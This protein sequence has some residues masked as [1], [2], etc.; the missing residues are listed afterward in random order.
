MEK[1]IY[2]GG[3]GNQYLPGIPAR[4]ITVAVESDSESERKEADLVVPTQLQIDNLV[5]RY[6]GENPVLDAEGKPV[7]TGLYERVLTRRSRGG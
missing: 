1:L 6:K 5:T 4:D 2:V 3:G 7:P